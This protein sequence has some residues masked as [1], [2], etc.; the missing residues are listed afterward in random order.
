M[1]QGGKTKW[2]T[3]ENNK[4]TKGNTLGLVFNFF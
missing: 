1:S 3:P 4:K 2:N